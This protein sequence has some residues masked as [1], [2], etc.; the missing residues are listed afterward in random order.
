MKCARGRL[1]RHRSVCFVWL[2]L[3]FK[4]RVQLRKSVS[5]TRSPRLRLCSSSTVSPPLRHERQMNR[6]AATSL[7]GCVEDLYCTPCFQRCIVDLLPKSCNR[8]LSPAWHALCNVDGLAVGVVLVTCSSCRAH[9]GAH[10]RQADI[11]RTP[12]RN[13]ARILV[14][15]NDL[16][17]RAGGIAL[18]GPLCIRFNSFGKW[19]WGRKLETFSTAKAVRPKIGR[20]HGQ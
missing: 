6:Q 17:G 15:A 12:R 13:P 8:R 5:C 14:D 2:I 18:Q 9:R 20:V 16:A 4:H 7:V 19:K 1:R 3:L 11:Q 10:P